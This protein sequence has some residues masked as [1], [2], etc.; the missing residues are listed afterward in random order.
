MYNQPMQKGF[1]ESLLRSGIIEAKSGEVGPARRYLERVIHL[2]SD[3]TTLAEAWYWM[4]TITENPSEKHSMLENC[5]SHDL[6]HA[7]ARR[8]LALLDGTLKPEDIINPDRLPAA[9]QKVSHPEAD[10]IMCPQCGARMV[11]TPDGGTLVCDFC[12]SHQNLT[13]QKQAEEQDFLIAMATARGHGKPIATQVF[14]CQSCGAEFILLPEIV[15]S[16]CAYCESPHVVSLAEAR[17]LIQPEGIIPHVMTRERAFHLLEVWVEEHQIKPQEELRPPRGVYLPIWTFDIGGGIEYSGYTL[18]TG[19]EYGGPGQITTRIQDFYAVHID[20]LV[21]PA[22]RN[23]AVHMARL[24]PSFDLRTTQPYDSRFLANWAAEVYT[25]PMSD[26]SLD[27]RSQAYAALKRDLPREIA[28]LQN[29]RTSSAKL[30]IESFKLVLLP[31]WMTELQVREQLELVLING[32][33]GTVEGP[34]SSDPKDGLLDW[35]IDIL[36][37]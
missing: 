9:V 2:S 6:R 15:S 33:N 24:L 19:Q 4:S 27:A 28:S 34:G 22:S 17:E 29:L 14:H 21:V 20:D 5:L 3:H 12:S 11:Y 36:E 10:R 18:D 37:D 30:I 16:S 25:V 35:L 31:V 13:S 32:Q 23:T 8:A 7:R 26:A 1:V